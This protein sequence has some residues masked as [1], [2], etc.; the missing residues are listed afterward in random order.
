MTLH[1]SFLGLSP[2]TKNGGTT[3]LNEIDC[4][5]TIKMNFSEVF[6]F[7]HSFLLKPIDE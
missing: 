2:Q 5:L 1:V 7:I 3:I 4:Y 6:E